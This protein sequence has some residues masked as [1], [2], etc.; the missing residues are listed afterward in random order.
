MGMCGR[1]R[2][3]SVVSDRAGEQSAG[4]ARAW[5][6]RFRY[7]NAP[8]R[9]RY[10]TSEGQSACATQPTAYYSSST[11]RGQAARET[12]M[13]ITRFSACSPGVRIES[14]CSTSPSSTGVSQV[15][16]VPS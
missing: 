16:Q 12:Q 15:P 1:F 5:Q 2:Q 3:I 4:Q 6:G 11:R 10:S 14:R 8:E 9:V 7:A 13:Y